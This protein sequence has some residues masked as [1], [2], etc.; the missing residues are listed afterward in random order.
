MPKVRKNHL[1]SI[2]VGFP[3]PTFHAALNSA[4][5]KSSQY[6]SRFVDP[7]V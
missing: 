2:G 6:L 4:Y 7:S 1:F 5:G 3:D